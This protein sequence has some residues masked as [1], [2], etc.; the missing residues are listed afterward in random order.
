M[1][2]I[3]VVDD[4]EAIQGLISFNLCKEGFEEETATTGLEA[5]DKVMARRPDLIIL[6]WVLPGD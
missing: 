4:E 3:L 5:L 6:D 1:P 2:F